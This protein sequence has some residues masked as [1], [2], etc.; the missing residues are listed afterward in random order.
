VGGLGGPPLRPT[1]LRMPRKSNGNS[2]Y[3]VR[4]SGSVTAT[5]SKAPNWGKVALEPVISSEYRLKRKM[6]RSV[7]AELVAVA[8]R[9]LTVLARRVGQLAHG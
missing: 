8:P 3:P 1:P 7:F 2:A 4:P 6:L 5:L 9:L